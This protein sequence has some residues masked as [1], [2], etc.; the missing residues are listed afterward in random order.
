[1]MVSAADR[2]P[3]GQTGLL[4]SPVCIGTSPLASMSVLYGY[5]VPQDRAEATIMA[6]LRGPF[7]F[8]DTSN[9][10]GGGAAEVRIGRALAAAGG[11]P[12][13]FVLATKVDADPVTG[14]FSAERVRRS[15]TE[16]LARL[17]VD[18]VE[19]MYLHDPEYHLTFA[20]AMAPGGPVRALTELREQGV[21]AHLGV[22]GGPVRLMRDFVATG[23]FD[24][25]LNHNR[26]T[27]LDRSAGPLLDDAVQRGMAFI[28]GAP[29]GGGI[30]AKGPDV[31]PKYAY[32]P[33]SEPLVASV[34]AMRRACL[35]RGV[36]LTAAAL[37]FSV[38]EPRVTSTVVGVSEPE[39]IGEI[40][41]LMAEHI[42]DDLWA[43]LDALAPGPESWLN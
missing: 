26:F 29:Y 37:Q 42:P 8:M 13:G 15:V 22:A 27:L 25:V 4:V 17:G 10:Y 19:L 2:R 32:R 1:M 5:E 24:V 30:L 3:L 18:R 38:R 23:E 33:A 35:A 6:A 36:S 20:E 43:E 31:Q 28:N 41:A 34:R 40:T 11:L 14:N 39:R 12:A 21:V 9:N 7:N 16:S